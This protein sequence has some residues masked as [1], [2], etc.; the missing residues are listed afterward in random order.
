MLFLGKD[1]YIHFRIVDSDSSPVEGLSLSDFQVQYRRDNVLQATDLFQLLENGAGRYCLKYSPP[2]SGT[3]YIELYHEPTDIRVIDVEDI[4][5]DSFTSGTFGIQLNHDYGGPDALRV[6][7]ENPHEYKLYVYLS[8]DWAMYKRND[9]DA[10]AITG[11]DSGGRW[12]SK[13]PVSPD[14]Y[15]IV[16]KRFRTIKVIRPYLRVE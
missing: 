11:L 3:E 13:I 6:T 4:V 9:E 10:I 7:E 8:S 16:I 12:L 5:Q 14:T 2:A 1:R 15:H